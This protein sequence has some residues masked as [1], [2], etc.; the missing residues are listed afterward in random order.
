M[1]KQ[2]QNEMPR[3]K[4]PLHTKHVIEEMVLMA[5]LEARVDKPLVHKSITKWDI[6]MYFIHLL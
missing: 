1:Q 2:N 5:L 3:Y 4:Y 6:S